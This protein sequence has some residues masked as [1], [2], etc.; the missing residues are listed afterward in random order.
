[1]HEQNKKILIVAAHPDDEVLGCGATVLALTLLGNEA[2]VLIL[3]EGV[4]SR[5]DTRQRKKREGMILDLRTQAE[6]A[7]RLIGVKSVECCDFPDNR[8]DTVPLIEIVKVIERKKNA[9]KP[10]IVFTHFSGDLNIDHRICSGATLTAFRPMQEDT[11]K[12]LYTYEILSSTEWNFGS[13]AAQFRPNC[14]FDINHTL[15]SKIEA[16]R[17]YEFEIREYPHPRSEKAIKIL[18]Q[19]RGMEIGVSA[20]EAFQLIRSLK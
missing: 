19:K 10:D 5:D 9:V 17:Q 3:G 12:E 7:N 16:M 20:A 14:Y 15:T 6:K 11:V 2:H 4:T 18:A 1:M 8:F 13:S